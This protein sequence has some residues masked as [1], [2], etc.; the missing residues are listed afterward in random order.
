MDATW[1]AIN[2]RDF[3]LVIGS[4]YH[5]PSFRCDISE[6]NNNIDKI[7]N[8]Y[9]SKNI[10]FSINGDFNAKHVM[11]T[12]KTD[13]RGE[14][15]VEWM[16]ENELSVVNDGSDTFR[17]SKSKKRSAIDLSI[18][19][20]NMNNIINNWFVVEELYDEGGFSDNFCLI[21]GLVGND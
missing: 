7:S 16:D 9:N 20:N 15:V 4:I 2:N 13:V 8:E 3:T 6:I 18:V 19:S 10:Y 1:I 21:M 5:S 11:W 17:N 12:R 14:N